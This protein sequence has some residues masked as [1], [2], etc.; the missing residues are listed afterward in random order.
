MTTIKY[1]FISFLSDQYYD[2]THF[3]LTKRLFIWFILGILSPTGSFL[4]PSP[5]PSIPAS[6]RLQPSPSQ[7]PFQSSDVIVIGNNSNQDSVCDKINKL[8]EITFGY[9]LNWNCYY[10]LILCVCVCVFRYPR[11]SG[12]NLLIKSVARTLAL[13]FSGRA[14][15]NHRLRP[16]LL[17]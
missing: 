5:S 6:P 17:A 1:L 7:S 14:R 15:L 12:D 3:I 9:E 10:Y 13:W 8:K 2:L 11:Q 4:T 16:Q